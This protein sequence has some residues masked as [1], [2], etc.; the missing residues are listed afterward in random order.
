MTVNEAL[1]KIYEIVNAAKERLEG[2]GFVMDVQTAY[3]SAMLQP[4]PDANKARYVNVSLVVSKVDGK[5]GEEYCLSLGAALLRNHANEKRLMRDI[6]MFQKFVDDTVDTLA[7]FE[8][9]NAGLDHL[10]QKAQEEYD[11]LVSK[12]M[13]Q[14]AKNRKSSMIINVVFIAMLVLLFFL[15][16]R[17]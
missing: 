6:E 1:D 16:T 13:E 15:M 7:Q 8:D 11:E 3:Y 4:L 17:K 12:A 2:N 14:Q 5:E 10:T 9:K